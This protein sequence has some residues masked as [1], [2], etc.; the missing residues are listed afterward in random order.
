MTEPP[1]LSHLLK[2]ADQ[3][4]ALRVAREG[5]RTLRRPDR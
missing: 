2:L 4:P 3:G 1:S 5:I